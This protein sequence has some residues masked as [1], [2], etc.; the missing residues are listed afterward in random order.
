MNNKK[1]YD[2]IIIGGSYAGLSAAMALG[3]SLRQVLVIDSGLA[4]NHQTPHS[5]NFLTRDGEKPTAIAKKA[6]KQVLAYDT[7]KLR[8]AKAEN[9]VKEGDLFKIETNTEGV[10]YAKKLLFA[11]GVVDIMPEIKGFGKCWGISVL[12]CPYCH[13]YEVAN[14]KL[15][16]LAN[17]DMAFEM[18]KLIKNWTHQLTLFTNGKSLLNAEQRAKI[19]AH[20]IEIVEKEVENI[21][22][23]KGYIHNL[24][25]KDKSSVPLNALF[26]RTAFKQHCELPMF[27]GCEMNEMGYV[28]T[29]DF[30]RT[31]VEG[32]YAAGDNTTQ[33]RSVAFAIAAGNIAGTMMN[34]D[35]IE[36]NL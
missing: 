14:T 10:F 11:T 35:L 24:N 26:A 30:K 19:A 2:V 1:T 8:Q 17:G 13:G 31:S 21:E 33:F 27:L 5:H 34:K 20:P 36:E 32:V 9:A 23:K 6:M 4:C 3:R 25:F 15:G 12:H 28:K 22:H 7:V 16:I 29:D 18:V